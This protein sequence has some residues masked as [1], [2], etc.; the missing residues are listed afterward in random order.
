MAADLSAEK[1]SG[2]P[3]AHLP[4]LGVPLWWPANEDP[5]FYDDRSVFRLPKTESVAVA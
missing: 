3:F 4:V 1:L 5:S 2:K